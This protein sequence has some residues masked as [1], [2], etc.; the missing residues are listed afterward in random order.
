M[1]EMV[2]AALQ[3]TGPSY[4]TFGYRQARILDFVF[5]LISGSKLGPLRLTNIFVGIA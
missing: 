3:Y 5:P 1:T 4:G 2:F